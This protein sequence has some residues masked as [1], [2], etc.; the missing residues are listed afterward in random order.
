MTTRRRAR[1]VVL[2]VLYE[3]DIHPE[4]DPKKSDE[5]LV[6]R[7]RGNKPLV[8]FGR[9]L[10]E[11]VLKNR[12]SLDKSLSAKAANWSLRRMASIDRNI[13]R[14]AAYEILLGPTP[15]PVAINEAIE[16]AKRYGSK[17]SGQFVNGILDRVLAEHENPT[18]SEGPSGST[19]TDS[20]ADDEVSGDAPAGDATIEV[21]SGS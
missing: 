3:D 5:F 2:Q 21:S 20:T 10:L 13:L 12:W 17:Q 19:T 18:V 11:G 6:R 4:R 15:G 14:M 1:E 16:L 8:R 7:M 9:D